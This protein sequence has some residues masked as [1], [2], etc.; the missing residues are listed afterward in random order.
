MNAFLSIDEFCIEILISLNKKNKPANGIKI[1]A[2]V[3]GIFDGILPVMYLFD[4]SLERSGVLLTEAES[5]C[6]IFC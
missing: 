3:I 6:I 1:I 4:D 2:N 5:G